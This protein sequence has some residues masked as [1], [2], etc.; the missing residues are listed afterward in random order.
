MIRSFAAV[1]LI[2]ALLVG[3]GKAP[4]GNG[5]SGKVTFNGSP[6]PAGT[7]YFEPDAGATGSQGVAKIVDGAYDTR[8]TGM[9]VTA[10]KTRVRIE[11]FEKGSSS[12]VMG[13][14]LC[15]W[16]TTAE[17]KEG[18]NVQDFEVPENAAVAATPDP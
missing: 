18:D 11:G 8:S 10:G 16:E 1:A 13:P 17:F 14:I 7:I 2:A 15:R 6:I 9:G 4:V 5:V 12:D 3:C